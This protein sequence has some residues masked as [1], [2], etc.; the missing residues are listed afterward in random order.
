M[1]TTFWKL[2]GGSLQVQGQA[3]VH[4]EIQGHLGRPQLKKQTIDAPTSLRAVGQQALLAGP[5]SISG[6]VYSTPESLL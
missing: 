6:S 3:G 2:T 4:R 1:P 5:Q